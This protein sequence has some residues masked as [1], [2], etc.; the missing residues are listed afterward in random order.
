[1]LLQTET[2]KELR[3]VNTNNYKQATQRQ[4]NLF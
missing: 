1:M 3:V 2:S 4:L